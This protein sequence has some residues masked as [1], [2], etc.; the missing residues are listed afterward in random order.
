MQVRKKK[1][2]DFLRHLSDTSVN[3]PNV[4]LMVL[5]GSSE[6]TAGRNARSTKKLH[7]KSSQTSK[8]LFSHTASWCRS[9]QLCHGLLVEEGAER[10]TL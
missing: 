9:H 3:W 4:A 5:F 8:A 2:Q 7:R 6:R 10:L 1:S